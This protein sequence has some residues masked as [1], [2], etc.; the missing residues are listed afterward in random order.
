MMGFPAFGMSWRF[1][2]GLYIFRCQLAVSFREGSC[3]ELDKGKDLMI[4][5]T[6]ILKV[7]NVDVGHMNMKEN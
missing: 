2:G 5:K 4:S 3:R 1:T 7:R 6:G